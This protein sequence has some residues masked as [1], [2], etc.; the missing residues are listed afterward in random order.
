MDKKL[1]FAVKFIL[2]SVVLNLFSVFFHELGHAVLYTLEG[3][4]ISFYITHADPISGARS[5][6]GASGG[7]I[8][9]IILGL[10]FMLLYFKYNNIY[11]FCGIAAN[12]LFS[13][14]LMYLLKLPFGGTLNDESYIADML[15][16]KPQLVMIVF[17]ICMLLILIPSIKELYETNENEKVKQIL[18]YSVLASILSYLII[19]P[20][21]SRGL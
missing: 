4:K 16:I 8:F 19:I 15:G 21:D 20:L 2:V 13:R 5:L 14:V 3:Y 1:L 17:L 12:T 9:N 11:M 10:V 7:I 6:L 18:I